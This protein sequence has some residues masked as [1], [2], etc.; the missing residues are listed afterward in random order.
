[1][2]L[3]KSPIETQ[4]LKICLMC[5]RGCGVWLTIQLIFGFLDPSEGDWLGT[6]GVASRFFLT[7]QLFIWRKTWLLNTYLTLLSAKTKLSL[8]FRCE[9]SGGQKRKQEVMRANWSCSR[10]RSAGPSWLQRKEGVSGF[11][12]GNMDISSTPVQG[13]HKFLR[14]SSRHIVLYFDDTLRQTYLPFLL[15]N[16]N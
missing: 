15:W 16:S 14:T 10:C 6:N 3:S 2:F 7:V 8:H 5:N 11:T 9:T 13:V 4:Q 12:V 1:M